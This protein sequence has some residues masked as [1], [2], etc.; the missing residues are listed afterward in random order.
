MKEMRNSTRRCIHGAG[1]SG[2]KEAPPSIEG[3][4]RGGNRWTYSGQEHVCREGS[5]TGASLGSVSAI[6]AGLISPRF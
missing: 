2:K 3:F 5:G 6:Q 1:T 4:G